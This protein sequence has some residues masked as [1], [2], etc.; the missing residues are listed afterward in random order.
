MGT[1]LSILIV[2]AVGAWRELLLDQLSCIPE[3]VALEQAADVA[4]AMDA[5]HSD[6]FDVVF[7][8][9]TTAGLE[10]LD[11]DHLSDR[12]GTGSWVIFYIV[13]TTQPEQVRHILQVV[14]RAPAAA[15]VGAREVAAGLESGSGWSALRNRVP[16][17][18][19]G[20]VLLVRIESVYMVTFDDRRVVVR[21]ADGAFN[22]TL[23]MAEFEE[24]VRGRSFLRVHRRYVVNLD[25]VQSVQSQV[26]GTYVLRVGN[27]D[28]QYPVP[29]S[30]RHAI[31]LRQEL[32]L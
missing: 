4:G 16:V 31:A 5:L 3:V 23:R 11:W 1:T 24:R 22:S 25:H 13:P 2:G 17:L 26:N 15:A 32:R 10:G 12:P 20:Q 29:V 8:D 21:T 7:V 9:V 27:D 30:R 18:F 19:R 14:A 6:H 28:A